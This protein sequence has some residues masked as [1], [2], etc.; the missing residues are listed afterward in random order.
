MAI[1]SNQDGDLT[2]SIRV[3]KERLYSDFDLTFGARTTTDGDIFKKTDAAA[4]KQ[5][6]KTLI[7]TNRF[8]KPYRPAFG[9]NLSGL[10]FELANEETGDEILSRIKSTI[11]RYEP[12][13]RILD[14]E[15]TA[16]PD[17]NK[18]NVVIEFRVVSTGITDVLKIVLGSIGDCT[19][20]FNPA[21]PAE[22]YDGN[23]IT[24]ESL[25]PILTEAGIYLVADDGPY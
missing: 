7:L 4:V 15:V 12:R 10:L 9:G 17:Y 11:A 24:T 14:I 2:N 1:K 23:S 5:A 21:P 13:V 20:E 25:N 16:E 19:P 8:E 3:A 22:P 6:L 18:V